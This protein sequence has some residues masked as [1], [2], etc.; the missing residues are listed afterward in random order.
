MQINPKST[1]QPRLIGF[2]V[3]TQDLRSLLFSG[4]FVV[5]AIICLVM[6]GLW[7]VCL[8]FVCLFWM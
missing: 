7:F 3:G 5:V 8:G 4:V 6:V 2:M 1:P